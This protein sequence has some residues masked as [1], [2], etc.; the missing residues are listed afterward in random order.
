MNDERPSALCIG[1][2]RT[3]EQISIYVTLAVEEGMASAEEYVW[4]E[5]GTLNR[6]NGH[7][8]CDE[9]YIK[10]GQP[11]SRYGWKAP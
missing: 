2:N 11:S 5:E 8:L 3:P 6:E 1:C 10:A 7:F 4:H 9:C